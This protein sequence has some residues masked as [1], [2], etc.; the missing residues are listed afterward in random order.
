MLFSKSW[1]LMVARLVSLIVFCGQYGYTAL[2]LAAQQGHTEACRLLVEHGAN[3][4][5]VDMV[6][7][8]MA[9]V[10]SSEEVDMVR[11]GISGWLL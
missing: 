10:G 9:Q 1:W 6:R 11:V 8:A 4:D 2:T 5:E 3:S 7:V